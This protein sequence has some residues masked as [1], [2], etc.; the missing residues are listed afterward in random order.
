MLSAHE[1]TWYPAALNEFSLEGGVFFSPDLYSKFCEL[2]S[3]LY[4]AIRRT[5]PGAVV[6]ESLATKIRIAVY[7]CRTNRLPS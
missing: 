7:G 6:D 3:S 2:R 1:I 5:E 4:D